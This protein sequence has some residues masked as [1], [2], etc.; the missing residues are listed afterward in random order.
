MN[1]LQALIA[2]WQAEAGDFDNERQFP[3][4]AASARTLRRCADELSAELSRHCVEATEPAQPAPAVSGS[5]LLEADVTDEY[6]ASLAP[7]RSER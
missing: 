5:Y 6:Y 7:T 2:K 4:I 1:E 3:A